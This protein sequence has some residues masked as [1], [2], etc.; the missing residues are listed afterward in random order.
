MRKMDASSGIQFEGFHALARILAEQKDGANTETEVVRT[1]L[2]SFCKPGDDGAEEEL[3]VEATSSTAP[4]ALAGS[5]SSSCC[6]SISVLGCELAL[7]TFLLLVLLANPV[8]PCLLAA[9]A[10]CNCVPW[11]AQTAAAALGHK[12][13]LFLSTA[14]SGHRT[15]PEHTPTVAAAAETAAMVNRALHRSALLCSAQLKVPRA[16]R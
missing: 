12:H 11:G 1:L 3:G 14:C 4:W 15:T 5:V 6:S 10:N 9:A 2:S 16:R 7:A 13:E 8:N